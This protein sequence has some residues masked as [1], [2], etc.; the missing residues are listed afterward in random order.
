[1]H[2]KIIVLLLL[3]CRIS[4]SLD[5]PW[6]MDRRE[7]SQEATSSGYRAVAYYVNWFAPF[8]QQ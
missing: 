8:P 7:A 2:R 3:V 4:N 6:Q 1:M 5:V